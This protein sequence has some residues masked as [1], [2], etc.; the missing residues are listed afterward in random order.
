MKKIKATG[1]LTHREYQFWQADNDF[2]QSRANNLKQKYATIVWRANPELNVEL[3]LYNRQ[4]IDPPT[5][6][7]N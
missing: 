3:V 1:Y 5:H 2:H 7:K 6:F 4:F